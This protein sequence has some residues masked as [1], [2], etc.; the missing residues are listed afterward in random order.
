V[1]VDERVKV[2]QFLFAS[3]DEY[4]KIIAGLQAEIAALKGQPAD[5]PQAV[6]NSP[7]S[8]NVTP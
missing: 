1:Q 7:A 4:R 8:E 3:C 2:I 6:P 5:G